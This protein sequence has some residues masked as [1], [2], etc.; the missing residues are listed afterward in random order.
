MP[1]ASVPVVDVTTSRKDAFLKEF[2]STHPHGGT[3]LV[4]HAVDDTQAMPARFVT[5]QNCRPSSVHGV[6]EAELRDPLRFLLDPMNV[7]RGDEPRDDGPEQPGESF[8]RPT[9]RPGAI[10]VPPLDLVGRGRALADSSLDG[11]GFGV[12][13]CA[14][15][16]GLADGSTPAARFLASRPS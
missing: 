3:L 16:D 12:V 10:P 9:A 4:G 8:R 13:H 14:V 7:R 1:E 15:S 6:L 5:D 2:F 11:T